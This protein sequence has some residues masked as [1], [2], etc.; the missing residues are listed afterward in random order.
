MK[1]EFIMKR[2]T[3]ALLTAALAVLGSSCLVSAADITL[4]EG[5]EER[6]ALNL[7]VDGVDVSDGKTAYA[8]I[9]D[10]FGEVELDG[11]QYYA[12]TLT[13]LCA[14]D[15]SEVQGAFLE[16]T[17]GFVRYISAVDELY[18]AA[19]QAEEGGDYAAV[20]LEGAYTYGS[21]TAG[22]SMISG[23]TNV[24]MVTEAAD[25][26]VAV[27]VNGEEIGKLIMADFMK[28]TPVGE[29]KVTTGMFDGSFKYNMGD[30]T[31]EGRFL[32]IDYATMLAK[33]EGLG[34]K[35]EGEIKEVEYYGTPGMGAEGKNT[36][37][38][39]YPD[40]E[41]YFGNVQFFCM[42]DGMVRNA[43]VKDVPV[44]LAAFV[45]GA[46]SKWLTYNMTAIN[47]ITE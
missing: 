15:L 21:I 45:N 39:L 41:N 1:G 24:F 8:D 35:V 44:G 14:Y 33:L 18:L 25:F 4:P 7:Y 23:I 40:E 27:Q 12:V 9:I 26:E 28:K 11:V 10:T 38:A 2:K 31:Y 22:G 3:V 36:E 30:S 43:E 47:F 29:E 37:Y 16:T 32:G 17:D 19:F 13:D 42:Y 46:G 20:E 5:T 6:N 34:M